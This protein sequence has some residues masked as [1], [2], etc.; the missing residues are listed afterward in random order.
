MKIEE[1]VKLSGTE[2]I[3]LLSKIADENDCD[4]EC[5]LNPPYEECRGCVARRTLNNI[6]EEIK[7][8]LI[9]QNIG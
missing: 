8:A 1:L 2:R 9:V 6:W 4:G 3:S 5:D 7:D